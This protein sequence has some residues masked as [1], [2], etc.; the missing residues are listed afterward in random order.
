MVI[1][2]E[3]YFWSHRLTL[4]RALRQIGFDVVIAAAE[5]R[6][7]RRD[8]EADG[9]RFVPLKL[10][11]RSTSLWR[12]CGTLLQLYRLYRRERPD[13]VHHVTIKP[14]LYGSIAARAAGVPAI[15]NTI[16]G[17]GYTFLGRGAIGRLRE[18]IV[19]AAY[20]IALGGSRTT[21][22]FQN[23]D[24]QELF[25]TRGLIDPRRAHVILGSGVDTMRFHPAPEP[26]GVPVVVLASRLLWD[27]G[28][29][30]IVDASR[31]LKRRGI[32]CRVALVGV[33]DEENPNSV[34]AS[35]LRSWH[36][37]GVIEW[38][39][40]RSDMPDVL[41]S[42]ALVVLPTYYREGVPLTLLEAAAAARPIITSDAPGCRE[43]VRHGVN[44]LLVPPRDA[45]ALADAMEALLR[46]PAG[47]REMGNRSREIAVA[48][49]SQEHVIAKT[50]AVYQQTLK[51]ADA[52]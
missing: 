20:W 48:C 37:E 40:L 9:F 19:S 11:R 18:S 22:I 15:V 45:T 4:A 6:D 16:P 25:I 21:V 14:V 33:P 30:E 23:P 49:F 2:V 38:W 1:N 50:I 8:I 13:L 5:E 32:A 35:T 41:K 12:E 51:A 24:D 10:Q 39:G 27:K 42:A 47:R 43:V 17:L 34:P 29:G 46:D 7:R 52:H 44:G 36:Q 26:D 31:M 3:W 28:I